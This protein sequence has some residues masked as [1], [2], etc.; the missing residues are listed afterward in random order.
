MFPFPSSERVIQS[1]A[2]TLTNILADFN[3]DDLVEA[4]VL[5]FGIDV[6]RQLSIFALRACALCPISIRRSEVILI[7]T[8]TWRWGTFRSCLLLTLSA[9][10]G[11]SA[12]LSCFRCL[13]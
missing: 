2:Q 9:L 3:P 6:A 1:L 13:L 11:S 10:L 4:I 12:G 8:T 5:I 7:T